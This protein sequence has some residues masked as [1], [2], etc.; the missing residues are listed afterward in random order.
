MRENINPNLFPQ[1]VYVY[2][3]VWGEGV[4]KVLFWVGTNWN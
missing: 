4:E 3:Y 2:V 1:S